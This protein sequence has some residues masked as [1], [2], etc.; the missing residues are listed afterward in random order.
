MRMV[1]RPRTCGQ[2]NPIQGKGPFLLHKLGVY[3]YFNVR[4]SE[5]GKK[6]M[7]LNVTECYRATL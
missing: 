5:E 1:Q 4:S 6:I 3:S 2:K 7:T